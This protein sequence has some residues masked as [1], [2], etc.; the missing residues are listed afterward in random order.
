MVSNVPTNSWPELLATFGKF[1][2]GVFLFGFAAGPT[3]LEGPADYYWLPI[4]AAAL[5]SWFRFK[6]AHVLGLALVVVSVTGLILLFMRNPTAVPFKYLM[7]LPIIYYSAFFAVALIK[8]VIEELNQTCK[9]S[10]QTT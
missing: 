8:P 4:L 7:P 1:L 2:L 3:Q 6:I 10:D 5:L 9:S